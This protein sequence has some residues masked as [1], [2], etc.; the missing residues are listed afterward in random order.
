MFK[1]NKMRINTEII[2]KLTKPHILLVNLL[3]KKNE[4]FKGHEPLSKRKIRMG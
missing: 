1:L 4:R 2:H 3:S